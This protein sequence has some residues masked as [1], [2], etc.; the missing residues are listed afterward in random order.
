MVH[1]GEKVAVVLQLGR[2]RLYV[3]PG[4]MVDLETAERLVRRLTPPGYTYPLPLHHAD[5]VSK[6]VARKLDRGTLSPS[7]LRRLQ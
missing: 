5:R 7:D 1:A 3:S 6:D 4:H 2:R